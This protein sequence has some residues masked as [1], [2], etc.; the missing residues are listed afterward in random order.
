ML[1]L[2]FCSVSLL[3]RSHTSIKC[4][5]LSLCFSSGFWGIKAK[6]LLIMRMSISMS[7]LF[8]PDDLKLLTCRDAIHWRILLTSKEKS[9]H[10]NYTLPFCQPGSEAALLIANVSHM[11]SDM[12]LSIQGETQ[13]IIYSF[14]LLSPHSCYHSDQH[15]HE[16]EWH[17]IKGQQPATMQFAYL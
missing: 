16:F 5:H 6:I 15:S 3:P 2:L 10:S 4:L 17:E 12:S 11:P 14:M 8:I 9:L 1:S 13:P 7:S